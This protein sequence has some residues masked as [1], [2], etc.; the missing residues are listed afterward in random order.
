MQCCH[1]HTEQ[2]ATLAHCTMADAANARTATSDKTSNGR[3]AFGAGP[4]PQFP[5]AFAR[6][7]VQINHARTG[8]GFQHAI[9]QRDGRCH[10]RGIQDRAGIQRHA[11]TV[12][13]R[14]TTAHRYRHA[15]ASRSV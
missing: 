1:T 8:F 5:T 12:I 2:I 15:M 10:G 6:P 9:L 3:G 13:T 11:L 14:R 4:K 7:K